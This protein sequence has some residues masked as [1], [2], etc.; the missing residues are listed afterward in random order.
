MKTQSPSQDILSR[1]FP[2]IDRKEFLS[3]YFPD[4]LA[5]GHG[6]LSRIHEIADDPELRHPRRMIQS[7]N[8]DGVTGVLQAPTGGTHLLDMPKSLATRLYQQGASV[9]I[10]FLHDS[11]ASVETLRQ[12]INRALG[13]PREDVTSSSAFLSPGDWN[14]GFHFVPREVINIQ[15]SGRKRWLVAANKQVP[16]AISGFYTGLLNG[17]SARRT[18][19]PYFPADLAPP[20]PSEWGTIDVGPGSGIFM[21]R[22]YWHRVEALEPSISICF[23]VQTRTP[24]EII[25]KRLQGQ[26]I[27]DARWRTP[28]N[29][30]EHG[31]RAAVEAHVNSL[32]QELRSTLDGFSART[33]LPPAGKEVHYQ[34]RGR[35]AVRGQK[36]RRCT[37][38]LEAPDAAPL[39]LDFEPTA[40][41]LLRWLAARAEPF[42]MSAARA[43]SDAS[44]TPREVDK[45]LETLTNCGVLAPHHGSEGAQVTA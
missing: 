29:T 25:I 27:S 26:L 23:L 6:P 35:I 40:R 34:V 3:S 43:K 19:V 5:V 32:L 44:A 39:A 38:V 7:S 45:V 9:E 21:P 4:R 2:N 41:P 24:L 37:A 17:R 28:L 16:H 22:G 15:L 10:P 36:G 30:S 42:P 31:D 8:S 14:T 11:V 20:D 12:A 13:F 1:L 33:V 18:D